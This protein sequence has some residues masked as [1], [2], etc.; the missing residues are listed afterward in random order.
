MVI[1]FIY[2]VCWHMKSA[3]YE[4]QQIGLE[5]LSA[6]PPTVSHAM[7]PMDVDECLKSTEKMLE[8][9]QCNICERL[10]LTSHQLS[11]PAA[12]WWDA[13]VE[14]HEEL[15]SIDWPKFRAAFHAH[16]IT[17]GVI[18]LKKKGLRDLK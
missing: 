12:D 17:Q 18:K 13:Y 8:V 16:H 11:G 7:E 9:V 1:S 15:E 2:L 3:F 6:M 10:L 14:A 5:I 4:R